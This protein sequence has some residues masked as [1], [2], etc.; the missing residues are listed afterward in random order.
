MKKF[1]FL[2]LAFLLFLEL[3]LLADQNQRCLILLDCRDTENIGRTSTFYLS[4][5]LQSAIAEKSIPILMHASV[6]NSFVERRAY[7]KQNAQ[8]NDT[9]EHK[10]LSLY[11]EINNKI[12]FWSSQYNKASEDL[13]ENKR[14]IIERVNEE[15]YGTHFDVQDFEYQLLSNYLTAFD[16]NDWFVY[17]KHGFYLLIPKNYAKNFG[18]LG[19]KT[20]NLEKVDACE[21][22]GLNYFESQQ[23]SSLVDVLPN[24]FCTHKDSDD[25]STRYKWDIVLSGH[26]GS[27]YAENNQEGKISWSGEP[28]I[29]DLTVPEFR[30]VLDFFQT[31]LNTH[32]LH[33]SS[34]YAGGNHIELAFE[35]VYNFAIIC[36][37][38][39]DC[40]TFCK[41][42]NTLPSK[43]KK[44][45]TVDD[46]DYHLAV[47]SWGLNMRSPYNWDEFF[48]VAAQI[49]FSALFTFSLEKSEELPRAL[50]HITYPI[51][52]NISLLRP[53]GS[54]R[55]HPLISQDMMKIDDQSVLFEDGKG[56]NVVKV[57]LLESDSIDRDLILN[58][59]ESLRI[60]SIKPGKAQHYIRR[61]ILENPIDLPSAF[62]QAEFQI[63]DKTF[64]IDECTFPL[65]ENSLIC[66]NLKLNTNRAEIKNLMVRQHNT[67]YGHFIRI[68][69]TIG[70]SAMMIVAH[71]TDPSELDENVAILEITELSPEAKLEYERS[72]RVS[73]SL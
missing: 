13:V 52:A 56:K 27:F 47:K 1:R 21:D 53:P 9:K 18:S 63:Y 59:A 68:F 62:W 60:I 54:N 20:D 30:N 46:L 70:D 73:P 7:F 61:L 67:F 34:C 41:W 12:A 28:L 44:N 58:N 43:Q 48:K 23:P 14:L 51:I 19:F 3:N 8:Q 10:L 42:T 5:K 37:C 57:I 16:S 49:D 69:F 24:F 65:L 32:L 66:S 4:S 25:R 6:W 29:A 45:L 36:D 11:E 17:K 22:I 31:Q 64:L 35:K 71:K 72:Y 40:A 2:L 55:F 15:F 38:L 50:A 39:T 26:G 33:Y